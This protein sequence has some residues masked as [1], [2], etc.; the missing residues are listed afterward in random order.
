VTIDAFFVYGTLKRGEC[1]A[2]RWPR[3]PRSVEPAWVHG[4]LH[5]RTDYPALT[6]GGDRVVGELWKFAS[7]DVSEVTSVL[8]EI[9]GTGQAGQSDLYRREIVRVFALDERSLG[10]AYTYHYASDPALD[11]FVRVRRPPWEW[12]ACLRQSSRP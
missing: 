11:G 12:P 10:D 4:T 1:R 7:A 8:D 5:C 3:R 9:E 6:A 2:H